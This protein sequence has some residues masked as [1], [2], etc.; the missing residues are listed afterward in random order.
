MNNHHSNILSLLE[1]KEIEL[2]RLKKLVVSLKRRPDDRELI[3]K[4]SIP[5]FYAIWE[6]FF[7]G[8]L[9]EYIGYIN[10]QSYTHNDIIDIIHAHNIDLYMNISHPREQIVAIENLYKKIHEYFN[11]Q[12]FLCNKIITK[13][14]VNYDVSS[15]MLKR[16][17][18]CSLPS[19][20]RSEL[21]KLLHF[22]NNISHGE[23]T[24]P[25]NDEV[26]N[27]LSTIVTNCMYDLVI[28]IEDGMT[29]GS[30][31]K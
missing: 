6:G 29:T 28:V 13:S 7:V 20:R 30:Y 15:N 16:L 21:N 3:A 2:A 10:A 1:T 18:L 26:I 25:F 17:S 11:G 24:V 8:S 23:G 5:A 4:Y 9:K 31:K 14:N 22:R 19:A 12:F 27:E